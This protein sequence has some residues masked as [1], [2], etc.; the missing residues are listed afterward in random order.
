MDCHELRTWDDT[1]S[2]IGALDA[3]VT[4][5]TSV[6]HVAASMG[7]PTHLVLTDYQY[8]RW[9][10]G[11]TTPWYPTMTVYRG[12][13]DESVRRIAARLSTR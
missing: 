2:L 7:R 8:W 13:V 11:E 9:G 4:V 5:D 10:T 12:N 6:A 1:A 3:I